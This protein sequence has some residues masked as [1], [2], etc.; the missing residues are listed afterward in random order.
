MYD[1]D[2]DIIDWGSTFRL[3][4]GWTPFTSIDGV[5]IDPDVV[6]F[7]FSYPGATADVIFTWTNGASPPDPTHTIQRKVVSIT[8][9][10]PSDP[11]TGSV[12]YATSTPH[13][14][15]AATAIGPG[16]TITTAGVSPSGYSGVFQVATVP[17]PTTFT[18]VNATT[19]T[20]TLISATSTET[21]SFYIEID[22]TF[23]MPTYISGSWPCYIQGEPGVSA[24]DIT[25]TKVRQNKV[26]F[27][28]G[29][30][31]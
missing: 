17:S 29:P 4:T 3:Q 13:N 31:T 11:A 22:T 28:N 30:D 8:S 23:Y 26:L 10:T 16:T 2:N 6:I 27:V 7:G 20:A 12:L 14:Y 1:D 21:G 19:G 24:L 9:V 18:I 5:V 15:Q 25:Q